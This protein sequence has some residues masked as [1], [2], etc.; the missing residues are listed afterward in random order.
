MPY[1]TVTLRLPVRWPSVAIL[2]GSILLTIS[3][4]T[5]QERPLLLCAGCHG[6]NGEGRSA[7]GYP[8]ISAQ[9][10]PYLLKQLEAYASGKRSSHIME[11]IAKMLTAEE[12][13]A[14]A[15]HFSQRHAPQQVTPLNSYSDLVDRGE[16]LARIGDNALRVQACQNCHGTGGQGHPPYNP[17]L[18]G[19]SNGYLK[20]ELIAWKT[21][22]RRTD[23]S[24]NM[25]AIAARLSD[26]DINAVA[27][28]YAR[29]PS[30]LPPEKSNSR[31]Q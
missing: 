29:L 15:T 7:A 17:Y 23:R 25:Q 2:L 6:M 24:G 31:R 10:A 1:E 4:S 8:R 30:P 19:L 18:A 21:G 20:K 5:A 28:Y 13:T 3:V 12:R 14:I 22:T 27:E 26:Q 11:P 9:S 16:Q